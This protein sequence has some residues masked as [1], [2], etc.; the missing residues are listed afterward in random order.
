[1][2]S[3][4]VSKPI[5]RAQDLNVSIKGRR[6]LHD[7]SF[8]LLQGGSLA[9]VGESGSGKTVTSRVFTGLLRRIGGKVISGEAFIG[10]QNVACFDDKQWEPL[11]GRTVSLV[12]QASL[13][14]LDPVARIGKQMIET[15]K[16]LNPGCTDP[17]QRALSLLDQVKLPGGRELMRKYPHELSGGMRQRIMIALALVAEPTLMVADEPT[18]ALD[19]TVQREILRL[20]GE[21]RQERN[22]AL[23]LIAHDLAAVSEVCENV[24]VMNQGR[25][26]ELG[27]TNEVLVHPKVPYTQALIAARPENTKPGHPLPVLS[28]EGVLTQASF[29]ATPGSKSAS[30]ESLAVL[31]GVT[32]TYRGNSEPSLFPVNL[33]ICTGDALGIVGESGSGKTT[34]G[35]ILV[36]ALVPTAGTIEVDGKD[37]SKIK[38]SNALRRDVQMV[39]QDPYGSLTPWR[40]PR[41]IVTDVVKR[42]RRLKKADAEDAAGQL[43]L[44]V[45]LP[46]SAFDQVTSSLSG[47]QC[48][49][50]GVARALATNPKLLVADEPTSSLDVSIQAQILNLLLELRYLKDFTLVLISHDLGVIRHMTENAIVLKDGKVVESGTTQDILEQP[51]HCYTKQLVAATPTISKENNDN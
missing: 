5:V 24:A 40:T 39:F 35:R 41:Q 1:M 29:D 44:D 7:V 37:W 33:D 31:R 6:I 46:E 27:P 45:G 9:L 42:W 3:H 49:R 38:R 21:L 20:L 11:H 43:L 22:M 47:G 10:D 23:L 12:P 25:I 15:I 18:T 17:F 14:G 30:R 8:N 32:M 51:Q 28:K 19:V 16:T 26:V 48:Q 36:G 50:A 2:A 13:S 34:L 4:S